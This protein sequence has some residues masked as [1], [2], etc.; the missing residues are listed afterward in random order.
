MK[1]IFDEND[2]SKELIDNKKLEESIRIF[3]KEGILWLNKI[4][5]EELLDCLNKK[6]CRL[7]NNSKTNNDEKNWYVQ[8]DNKR[9]QTTLRLEGIFS[10]A[11]I[12]GSS[13]IMQILNQIFSINALPNN[14][15]KEKYKRIVID[16]YTAISSY[17]NCNNQHLH[18]DGSGLF[19][20]AIDSI[21]PTHAVILGIPLIDLS[22]QNG[23]TEVWPESHIKGKDVAKSYKP[24]LKKGDCYIMD[25]RLLHRG[26]ANNSNDLRTIIFI[27]YA[28]P[29]WRDIANFRRSITSKEKALPIIITKNNLQNIPKDLKYLFRYF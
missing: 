5:P 10:E 23:T 21:L 17:P 8:K 28:L 29:W 12:Y 14:L 20:S 11:N 13:K 6:V 22:E 18:S 3:R 1:P 19:S 24:F 2:I 25:Y 9:I 16:S 7:A 4:F 26:L 15:V 27:R